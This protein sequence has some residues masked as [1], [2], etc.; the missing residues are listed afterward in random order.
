MVRNIRH[1]SRLHEIQVDADGPKFSKAHIKQDYNKF[2][3]A[4]PTVDVPG[5]GRQYKQTLVR[6]LN[7]NPKLSHDRLVRVR[8]T[9]ISKRNSG[10]PDAEADTTKLPAHSDICLFDD[11]VA[12][13]SSGT[14][15]VLRILRM[16]KK[17]ATRGFVEYKLP[18]KYSAVDRKDIVVV[19]Q[20]YTDTTGGFVLEGSTVEVKASEIVCHINLSYDAGI[21]SCGHEE[22]QL[23]LEEVNKMKTTPESSKRPRRSAQPARQQSAT[24]DGTVRTT[25]VAAPESDDGVRRSRRQRTVI[26]HLTH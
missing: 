24:D 14:M 7:D 18:V 13:T 11:Y 25:V 4:C 21:Y 6:L 1:I 26:T 3:A 17:G 12:V 16:R 8:Q 19:G 5:Y 2:R 20:L 9:Y 23:I 10:I 15:L 22:F